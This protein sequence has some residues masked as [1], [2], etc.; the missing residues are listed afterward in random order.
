MARRGK[1]KRMLFLLMV[2][3]PEERDKLEVL[4]Y[5]YEGLLFSIAYDIV[6]HEKDAEDVVQDTFMK[7]A[8]NI[9]KIGD[10][11]SP[12]TKSYLATISQNLAIDVTR[13]RERHAEIEYLEVFED[14][15]Y[16]NTEFE[17]LKSVDKMLLSKCMNQLSIRHK[18]YIVMKYL[19][20]M[21]NKQLANMLDLSMDG[22][23]QLDKRARDSLRKKLEKE[24]RK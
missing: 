18:N 10:V 15:V 2:E 23:R 7:A 14:A 1:K 8:L 3:T 16:E 22:V 24:M 19:H 21:E 9:K 17:L 4:F 12:A 5:K 6:K 20:G 13:E 11:D